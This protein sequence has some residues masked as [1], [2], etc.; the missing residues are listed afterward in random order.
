MRKC[1]VFSTDRWNEVLQLN[2]RGAKKSSQ[3]RVVSLTN[4]LRY[5][6]IVLLN[7]SAWL[8]HCGWYAVVVR[9]EVPISCLSSF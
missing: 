5:L 4:E 3:S 2:M 7:T 1:G 9:L 8:L 6:E